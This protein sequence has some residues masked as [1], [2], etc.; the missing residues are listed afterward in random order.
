MDEYTKECVKYLQKNDPALLQKCI[1]LGSDDGEVRGE[2]IDSS[3]LCRKCNEK[4]VIYREKQ[5]RSA[6]EGAT[7]YYYCTLCGYS[8]K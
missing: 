8:W 2:D 6:D 3:I 7:I 4:K 1:A 5:T